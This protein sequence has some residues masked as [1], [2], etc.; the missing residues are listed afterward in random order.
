METNL[1]NLKT[2]VTEHRSGAKVSKK[3]PEKV[4]ALVAELRKRH[5]IDEISRATGIGATHICHMTGPKKKRKPV[6]REVKLVASPPPAITKLL[7]LELRRGDGAELR[8]RLEASRE[9]L[10]NLFSEFLR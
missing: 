6:F 9:E 4:W 7:A 2:L 5:T 1:E 8:L 3:Y 10:S